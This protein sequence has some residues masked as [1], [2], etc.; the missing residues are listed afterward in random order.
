MSKKL[1]V[2]EDLFVDNVPYLE[3]FAGKAD[4]EHL[5]EYC[6]AIFKLIHVTYHSEIESEEAAKEAQKEFNRDIK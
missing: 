1:H 5:R 4:F 6:I 2:Y 3:T